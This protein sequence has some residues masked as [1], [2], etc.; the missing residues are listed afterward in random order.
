MEGNCIVIWG[1][2][3]PLCVSVI[4]D[5]TDSTEYKSGK[6]SFGFYTI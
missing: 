4:T 2:F 5:F 3:A 1:F 6:M